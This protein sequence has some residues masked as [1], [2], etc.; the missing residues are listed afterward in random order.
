MKWLKS[1]LVAGTLQVL[2]VTAGHAGTNLDQIK[3]AGVIK[4]GTEGTYAPFT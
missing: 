3:Q 2:A 4:V 1:L